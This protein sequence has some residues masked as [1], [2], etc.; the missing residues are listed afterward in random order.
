MKKF[1]ASAG[2]V[3]LGASLSHAASP[4]SGDGDKPWNFSLTV[5]G[6]YDDNYY[7]A[8]VSTNRQE[9]FGFEVRPSIGLHL[10]GQQTTFGANYSYSMRYYD[11]R[12]KNTADHSHEFNAW[13]MH[14]FSERYSLDVTDT[15][16]IAQEP[17]LLDP[18]GAVVTR[19]N[20]NNLRNDGNIKFH[21]QLTRLLEL[22]LGYRNVLVDY[23]NKGGNAF[24]PS[25]SGLIDRME[26]AANIDLRW[27]FRPETIGIFGYQFGLNDYTG[28][29]AIGFF[30]FTP[31]MSESRN[32]R[33]HYVYAGIEHN[34]H[35]NLMGS[36]RAGAQFVDYYNTPTSDKTVSPY[37]DVSL[38]YTYG[39]G[40]YVLLG[41]QHQRNATDAFS[42]SANSITTDQE[43]SSFYGA[44]NHAFT[45]KLIANLNGRY[46]M[47]T[48]SGGSLNNQTDDIIM[49]GVSLEYHF[50]RHLSAEI[51]YNYDMVT[52]NQSGRDY[53]R[54]RV[55]LGMTASY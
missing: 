45:P 19:S 35:R 40:S 2:L 7:L 53:D 29:E 55:F 22:V 17:T 36:V 33:S 6:F 10:A 37:A 4:F 38:R 27:Q 9:S 43:S 20:G 13:L 3:A 32:S 5:R 49:V 1:I 8:S 31:L 54:N 47:S 46:Q 23:E 28:K 48:Y 39:T 34:F 41:F 26:H 16:T 52:S 14:S 11:D 18:S 25:Y 15:F 24:A 50:N 30:G 42:A 21:A 44:I 51:G 12:K